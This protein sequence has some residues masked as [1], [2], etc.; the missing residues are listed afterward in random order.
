MNIKSDFV[1]R[2]SKPLTIKISERDA[3][4]YSAGCYISNPVFYDNREKLLVFPMF[5]VS[6]T[7]KISSSFSGFWDTSGFPLDSLY[8]QVHYLENL[9]WYR[10]IFAGE[11]IT[12]VGEVIGIIPHI[13]GTLLCIEYKGYSQQGKEVFNEI[14]CSLL[15]GIKCTD[16]GK[17]RER[18]P[19]V[20]KG[21]WNNAEFLWEEPIEISP[22]DPYIYDGCSNIHFPIHI[23][24][25]FAE[26]V[27]LPGPIYQGTAILSRVLQKF[28][29]KQ[30]YAP[31]YKFI[32]S[33][34]ARFASY[35]TPGSKLILKVLKPNN[36]E[37]RKEIYF[38]EIYDLYNKSIVKEGKVEF[39]DITSI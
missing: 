15:R 10:N 18:F 28:L 4:N 36:G 26:N 1:G 5:V 13:S 12:I 16:K 33:L 19:V 20:N 2:K 6:L 7:W 29:E 31:E 30:E 38:F 35:I 8:T 14:T 17:G 9:T 34:H 24:R 25:K 23:S 21:G 39:A 27:G 32:K 22:Y 37:E 11:V 3:L